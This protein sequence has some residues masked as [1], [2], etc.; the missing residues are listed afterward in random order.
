MF[1]MFATTATQLS[2]SLAYPASLH[3]FYIFFFASKISQ[4]ISIA[5]SSFV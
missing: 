3:L 2:S 1:K 4:S 5:Q